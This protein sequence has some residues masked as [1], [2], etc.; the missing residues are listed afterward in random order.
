MG[1]TAPVTVK[2]AETEVPG[3]GAG[4]PPADIDIF[5]LFAQ[6]DFG[7]WEFVAALAATVLAPLIWNIVARIE[8]RTH[9]MRKL[10]GSKYVTCYILAVWIF[11]FSTLR[12]HLCVSSTPLLCFICHRR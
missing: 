11:T 3:G 8:F 5:A 6:I 7:N 4:E 10:T 2:G 9:F 12:D 1:D